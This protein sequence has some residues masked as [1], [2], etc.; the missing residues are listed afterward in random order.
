MVWLNANPQKVRFIITSVYWGL[1]QNLSAILDKVNLKEYRLTKYSSCYKNK[2]MIGCLMF[3]KK[4]DKSP[5]I[6]RKEE[7]VLTM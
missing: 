1:C 4:N 5:K 3:K 7:L 6:K 2:Q